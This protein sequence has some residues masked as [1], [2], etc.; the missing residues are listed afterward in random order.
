MGA[1]LIWEV[2]QL[3]GISLTL[4][5]LAM[6]LVDL[7]ALLKERGQHQTLQPVR[8]RSSKRRREDRNET[9]TRA[10]ERCSRWSISRAGQANCVQQNVTLS[11]P[12][13]PQLQVRWATSLDKCIDASALV[14]GPKDGQP[15]V[16]CVGSH[17][18]LF[19]CLDATSGN[20]IWRCK[21]P[22][23]VES[24]AALSSDG[25]SV[26]VGCYDGRLYSL[27]IL[28]GSVRWRV[29]TGAEVKCSP[30]VDGAG[31]MVLVGSY[32]YR[33]Y[34]LCQ[35]SGTTLWSIDTGAA[36]FSSPS[37]ISMGW[38]V[39]NTA[40]RVLSVKGAAVGAVAEERWSR[41]LPA[42][43]FSSLLAIGEL[44]CVGCADGLLYALDS[45]SGAMVW[46]V[47]TF[48]PIFSSPSTVPMLGHS[49]KIEARC[50]IGS[51]DGHLRCID[52][53]VGRQ[54]W[55]VDIGGPIFATPFVFFLK[56][57]PVLD[58][59]PTPS[60][61]VLCATTAGRVVVLDAVSG[62]FVASCQMNGETFGSPIVTE[63]GILVSCRDNNLYS[64]NL[65]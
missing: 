50:W 20:V 29:A 55:A 39:A 53:K 24:S 34:A 46:T 54:I 41:S 8:A 15:T 3:T 48:K 37:R 36:V 17:A 31:C 61:A 16:V 42:P 35:H 28:D 30:V 45:R 49:H 26:F 10:T 52:C 18:H 19:L 23:R 11:L 40:G 13:K 12:E 5:E 27:A 56:T 1:M 32:D 57:E 60:L 22:D 44:L 64:I 47:A 43:V 38:A 65:T 59:S 51:H 6:P 58:A 9:N 33:L 14:I 25:E 4:Q 62:K 63:F 2:G 7:E 21:L